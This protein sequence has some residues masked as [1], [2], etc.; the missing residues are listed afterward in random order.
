MQ[1]CLMQSRKQ[2]QGRQAVGQGR[3]LLEWNRECEALASKVSRADATHSTLQINLEQ[4]RLGL[5]CRDETL[6]GETSKVQE[7]EF[8]L[9]SIEH[10]ADAEEQRLGAKDVCAGSSC[11]DWPTRMCV[12]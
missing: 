3:I 6:A 9:R 5:Q 12:P 8:K 4:A 2:L 7:L 10:H 11:R 1:H